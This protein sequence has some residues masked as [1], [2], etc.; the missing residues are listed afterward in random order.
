MHHTPLE[1]SIPT[2]EME[3]I[4]HSSIERD[5]NLH[6]IKDDNDDNDNYST[7]DLDRLISKM[8]DCKLLTDKEVKFVC[9]K[10]K[11]ILSS[12]GNIV[13]VRSPVT[14]CGD[15]HGQ[16]Y[17]LIELFKIGGPCPETNYLFMG[18][19]VDRG[20]FSIEVVSLLLCLKIRYPTRIFLTRGNH[21][22]RQI[23]KVSIFVIFFS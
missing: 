16:F 9:E 7:N 6:D 15:I 10:S 20:Y 21:E 17:D 18:D 14:V 5:I 19:Y 23:T 2:Q 11:E 8:Y 3:S 12:E 4:H 13:R 22:S 1:T